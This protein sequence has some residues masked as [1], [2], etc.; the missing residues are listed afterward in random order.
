[1]T[2][3]TLNRS[4]SNSCGR[5]KGDAVTGQPSHPINETLIARSVQAINHTLEHVEA[6]EWDLSVEAASALV[7]LAAR[8]DALGDVDHDA[9]QEFV[10]DVEQLLAGEGGEAEGS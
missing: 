8:I 2:R 1:M 5:W 3:A 4:P 6:N 10:L 9:L 7:E